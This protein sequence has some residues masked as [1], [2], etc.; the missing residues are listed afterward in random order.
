M[1]ATILGNDER[2]FEEDFTVN[3]YVMMFHPVSPRLDEIT[4]PH[5]IA[6]VSED[7]ILKLEQMIR[8][9]YPQFQFTPLNSTIRGKSQSQMQ[10]N[11]DMRHEIQ[12]I[13]IQL[14]LNSLFRNGIIAKRLDIIAHT[15]GISDA[16]WEDV[17][18]PSKCEIKGC[19]VCI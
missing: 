10:K 1:V 5:Q 12:S 8:I 15:L 18:I 4:P 14:F 19:Q 11:K 7:S 2:T 3:Y 9:L 16:L 6:Y 13:F 17:A